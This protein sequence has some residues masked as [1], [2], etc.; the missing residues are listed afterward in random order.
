MAF[1]PMKIKYDDFGKHCRFIFN[2][3]GPDILG[4]V[5]G[6]SSE[7]DTE[8]GDIEYTIV[9]DNGNWYG[10]EDNEIKSYQVID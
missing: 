9:G 8:S 4:R 7:H 1:K 10:I 3:N 6:A 2:D 5:N